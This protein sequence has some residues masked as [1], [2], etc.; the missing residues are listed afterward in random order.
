MDSTSIG[1][2]LGDTRATVDTIGVRM[3]SLRVG[4]ADLTQPVTASTPHEYYNGVVLAPWPNRVRGGRWRLGDDVHQLDITEPARGGALHGLLSFADYRVLERSDDAVTLGARIPV[5][6]GWPFELDT[7]VRYQLEP[8]GVLVTHTARNRSASPA[9]WAVG[10]HPYLRVG[11]HPGSR[12]SRVSA[13][14][15]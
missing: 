2:R 1:L 13:G 9:P 8:D 3:L 11:A 7:T 6:H 5:Q 14:Q 4:D 10:A 15:Q 12:Q